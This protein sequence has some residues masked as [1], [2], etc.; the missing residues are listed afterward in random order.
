M[1][2]VGILQAS[3]SQ[4]LLSPTSYVKP[5]SAP[6]GSETTIPLRPSGDPAKSKTTNTPSPAG[7]VPPVNE[8][9]SAVVALDDTINPASPEAPPE[10]LFIVAPS[11]S[12]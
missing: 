7:I 11:T 3:P 8:K 6:V 2:L 4:S 9:P 1:V 5:I 10:A 12:N